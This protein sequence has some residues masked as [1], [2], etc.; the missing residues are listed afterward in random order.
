MLQKDRDAFGDFDFAWSKS[1][2]H[3]KGVFDSFVEAFTDLEQLTP[4]KQH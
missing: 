2:E 3:L 4:D 1:V